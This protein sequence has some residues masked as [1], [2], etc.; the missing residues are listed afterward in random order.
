[1]T[2]EIDSLIVRAEAGHMYPQDQLVVWAALKAAV[3]SEGEIKYYLADALNHV[4]QVKVN[5]E[6]AED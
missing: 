4:R 2:N 3:N 6:H 5:R 1:V